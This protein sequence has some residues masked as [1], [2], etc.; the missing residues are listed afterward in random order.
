M[1]HLNSHRM[2]AE[3]YLFVWHQGWILPLI[4]LVA[5]STKQTENPFFSLKIYKAHRV[6]L[7]AESYT[8]SKLCNEKLFKNDSG[9]LALERCLFQVLWALL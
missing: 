9:N 1:S 7:T 4:D 3:I 5:S 2:G 8:H 6:A